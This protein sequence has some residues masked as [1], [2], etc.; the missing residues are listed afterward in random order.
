MYQA[1]SINSLAIFK[2]VQILIVYYAVLY[3]SRSNSILVCFAEYR[4]QNLYVSAGFKAS[5]VKCRSVAF[6]FVFCFFNSAC[7]IF[8]SLFQ[9]DLLNEKIPVSKFFEGYL[10]HTKDEKQILQS[11]K[12]SNRIGI[13]FFFFNNLKQLPNNKYPEDAFLQRLSTQL[14]NIS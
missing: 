13:F 4:K 3:M 8:K 11:Y 5:N 10:S 12:T 14:I 6:I 2:L 9:L 7:I 1:L